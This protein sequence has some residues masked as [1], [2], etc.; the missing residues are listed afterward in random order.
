MKI[1]LMLDSPIRGLRMH[2][3]GG[4]YKIKHFYDDCMLVNLI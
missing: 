1:D 4:L 3:Q 2:V